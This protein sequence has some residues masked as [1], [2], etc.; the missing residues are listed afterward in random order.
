MAQS[1][2]NIREEI[3]ARVRDL[4]VKQGW[5]DDVLGGKIGMSGSS[6]NNKERGVRDFTWE[7]MIRLSDVFGITIDELV[8]GVRPE[9]LAAHRKT[10]LSN[11]SVHALK[12]FFERHS[13]KMVKGLNFALSSDYVLDALARYMSFTPREKGYYL[14]ELQV[15]DK[16]HLLD[17]RMSESLYFNVLGQNLLQTLIEARRQDHHLRTYFDAASDFMTSLSGEEVKMAES[18]SCNEYEE[19]RDQTGEKEES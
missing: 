5:T 3:G 1:V 16:E 10:G 6:L 17:C 9:N 19:T 7:E 12:F 8:R 4:R 13:F 2:E 15:Y 11:D 14:S 18:S